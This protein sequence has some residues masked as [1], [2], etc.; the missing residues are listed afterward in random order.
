MFRT[1]SASATTANSTASCIS[2]QLGMAQ[3]QV[4]GMQKSKGNATRH[5]AK[6]ASS[7]KKGKRYVAPKKIAAVKSAALHKVCSCFAFAPS[8]HQSVHGFFLY[9]TQWNPVVTVSNPQFLVVSG[10]ERKDQ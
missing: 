2:R 8:S 9:P 10:I 3:G 7:T 4:K 1:F 5:A 6:A